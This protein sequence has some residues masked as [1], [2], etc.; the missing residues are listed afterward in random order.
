MQGQFERAIQDLDEA[1]RLDSELA[2]VYFSRGTAYLDLGQPHQAIQDFDEANRLACRSTPGIGCY[3]SASHGDP[4]GPSECFLIVSY[5]TVH[6]LKDVVRRVG[7]IQA[8]REQRVSFQQTPGRIYAELQSHL[9]SYRH[10]S[11]QQVRQF[12]YMLNVAEVVDHLQ[13]PFNLLIAHL[14]PRQQ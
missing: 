6:A 4:D 12:R 8:E 11:V 5:S 2:P 10:L 1:I 7:Y 9:S 3:P 14:S 13:A